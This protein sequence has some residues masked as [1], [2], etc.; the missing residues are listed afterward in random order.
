MEVATKNSQVK[1][2]WP[3][4]FGLTPQYSVSDGKVIFSNPSSIMDPTLLMR[5]V[6]DRSISGSAGQAGGGLKEIKKFRLKSEDVKG[7]FRILDRK[8]DEYLRKNNLDNSDKTFVV[9]LKS[10]D[11]N[12]LFIKKY[13]KK[14]L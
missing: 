2:G 1:L 5:S 7:G 6:V 8:V 14:N 10:L 12:K 3:M 9:S 4:K 13:R 11:D